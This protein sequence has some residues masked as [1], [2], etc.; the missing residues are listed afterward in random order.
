MGGAHGGGVEVV[1]E[2]VGPEE[3]FGCGRRE[4][5]TAVAAA[6]CVAGEAA[7]GSEGFCEAREA[8]LR[9]DVESFLDEGADDWR[10]VDGVDEARG[11]GG[12]VGEAIDAAEGVVGERAGF[13]FVVMSEELGLVGGH[14]DGDGALALAGFAGEAE[15]EGFLDLFVLPLIGEDLT[16]HQLP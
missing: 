8:A 6:A 11:E 1:V 10:V 13:A 9:M 5:G 15:I 14:V 16:L 12:E 2:G 3:D 4:C 7:V